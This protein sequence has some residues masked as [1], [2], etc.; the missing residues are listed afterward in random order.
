MIFKN[1][2]GQIP[3]ATNENLLAPF[4][5]KYF[6]AMQK[7]AYG[8]AIGAILEFS[9]LINQRFNDAAPWKSKK[10]GNIEAMN[11]ALFEAAESARIIAILLLPFTPNLANKLLDILQINQDQRNFDNLNNSL[12]AGDKIN[13]PQGVFPRLENKN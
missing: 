3:Q 4:A 11:S 2:D 7:F 8:E 10:E 5:E 12:K 6:A 9:T 1:C 13:Q